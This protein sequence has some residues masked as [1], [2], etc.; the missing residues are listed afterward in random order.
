MYRFMAI[1]S[2]NELPLVR[3]N[4]SMAQILMKR[5]NV[6]DYQSQGNVHITRKKVS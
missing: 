1:A 6:V 4:T 3:L 5:I 2:G